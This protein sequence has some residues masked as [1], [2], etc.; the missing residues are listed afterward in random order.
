[1]HPLT[2]QEVLDGI[3]AL[4]RDDAALRASLPLGLDLAEPGSLDADVHATIQAVLARLQS[5]SPAEVARRVAERAVP[6]TRPAP[7]APLAQARALE[8]LDGDSILEG[9][10]HLHHA[11][12]ETDQHVVV[13]LPDRTLRLPVSASKAVRAVLDGSRLSV[14]ELPGLDTDEAIA[15][16][17]RLVR[18]GVAV[19][20]AAPGELR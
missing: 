17:R 16:T 18:E 20:A 7:V 10:A 1:V 12:R 11:L 3:V 19:L 14:R 6:S 9:R 4:V 2:R 13:T 5:V 8:S 15:L